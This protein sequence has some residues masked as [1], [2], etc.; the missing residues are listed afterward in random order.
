MPSIYQVPMLL[1]QQ[2]LI[3]M[4]RQFLA[5]DNLS[6]SPAMTEKGNRTWDEWQIR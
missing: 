4:V 3:P 1:E 6:V 5:L 2:R